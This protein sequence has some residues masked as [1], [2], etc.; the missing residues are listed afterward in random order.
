MK[1][2]MLQVY[3]VWWRKCTPEQKAVLAET[4][5]DPKRPSSSGIGLAYR[6]VDSDKEDG[7]DSD[8]KMQHGPEGYNVDSIQRREYRPEDY[9]LE[10]ETHM[11]DRNY[12]KD[13]VLDIIA[14]IVSVLGDSEHPENRLQATCIFLAIGMPGQPNMT[15]L[16][17]EHSLTRAAI[18]LRVKTIQRKLGLPPSVY[19][20]SDYAC[21]RLKK[22]K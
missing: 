16:A 20:K 9:Y 19:M 12:T 2:D 13:E 15:A 10:P 1:I 22:K 3:T 11:T 18:S 7:Y 6:Y 17:K 5:F 21:A 4:G 14:K 8:T